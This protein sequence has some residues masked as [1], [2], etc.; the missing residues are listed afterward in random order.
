MAEQ[1][2]VSPTPLDDPQVSSAYQALPDEGPPAELDALILAAAR[3]A[4]AQPTVVPMRRPRWL[5]PLSLAAS[6]MLA[7]GVGWQ[8]QRQQAAHPALQDEG[9]PDVA[10]AS[11]V[12]PEL[13]SAS[14]PA[15]VE[16]APAAPMPAPSGQAEPQAT[17]PVVTARA[18]LAPAAKPAANA[19]S[20]MKD[21]VGAAQPEPL[22]ETVTADSESLSQTAPEMAP[23]ASAAPA[24]KVEAKGGLDARAVANKPEPPKAVELE[25]KQKAA[26]PSGYAAPKEESLPP[27]IWLQQIRQLRQQGKLV[28]AEQALQRFRKTY[29]DYAIPP[30]LLAGRAASAP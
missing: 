11:A 14:S 2:A 4:V 28:E 15:A 29:P 25:K 18:R 30:D 8:V 23:H 3:E 13:L 1:R 20:R 24:P 7:I 21:K 27:A 12:A 5:V 22:A 6:L 26:A 17:A 9:S 10:M 16:L 19:E